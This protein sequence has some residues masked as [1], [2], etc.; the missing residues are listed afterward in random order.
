MQTNINR[1][2]SERDLRQQEG[3]LFDSEASLA[4]DLSAHK[5]HARRCSSVVDQ[6]SVVEE[7]PNDRGE[8][9][10]PLRSNS[11]RCRGD[12]AESFSRCTG[13]AN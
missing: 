2:C 6:V 1:R 12:A 11:S 4:I 7:Q 10:D 8:I 3:P 5:T 9:I 13:S